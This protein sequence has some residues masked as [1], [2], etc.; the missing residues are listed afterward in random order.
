MI[1]DFDTAKWRREN[2][3]ENEIPPSLK[4]QNEIDEVIARYSDSINNS[5]GIPDDNFDSLSKDLYEYIYTNF[6]FKN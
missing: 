5:W 2:I 6:I 1:D 4:I 3:F